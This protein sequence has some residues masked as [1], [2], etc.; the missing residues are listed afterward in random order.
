LSVASILPV[1]AID[2]TRS[3][4]VTFWTVTAGGGASAFAASCLRSSQPGSKSIALSKTIA[5]ASLFVAGMDAILRNPEYLVLCR[6]LPVNVTSGAIDKST[7]TGVPRCR[8]TCPK[9]DCTLVVLFKTT[10][11]PIEGMQ[12]AEY[13]QPIV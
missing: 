6:P 8:W 13:D 3:W 11:W 4:Y 7:M 5:T 1:K 12:C 10:I 2:W 9:P